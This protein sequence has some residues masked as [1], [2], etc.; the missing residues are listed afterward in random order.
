MVIFN[1][2]YVY[3]REYLS[4]WLIYPHCYLD[5]HVNLLHIYFKGYV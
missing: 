2:I 1:M 5:V 3:L 4:Y